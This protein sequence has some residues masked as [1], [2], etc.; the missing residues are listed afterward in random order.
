MPQAHNEPVPDKG[1]DVEESARRA[2]YSHA[3]HV[4]GLWRRAQ[5]ESPRKPIVSYFVWHVHT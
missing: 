5:D 4:R 2:L 3:F 1:A